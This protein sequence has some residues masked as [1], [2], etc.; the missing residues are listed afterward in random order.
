MPVVTFENEQY[1]G[2]AL[3]G[4]E[5]QIL[6]KQVP[7]MMCARGSFYEELLKEN[8]DKVQGALAVAKQY[9]DA[10]FTGLSAGDGEIGVQKIRAGH[11]LRTTGTTETP[12]NDWA[13]AFTSG[14][15]YW[16]GY[17]T[18]NTTAAN[19]DKEVCLLAL[20]LVFTQTGVPGVEELYWQIGSSI[21]PIEVIRDSWNADNDFGLRAVPIRPK[22]MV[23]KAT[24]LV[25]SRS[26]A[27][28]TNELVVLGVAFGMG[29]FLRQQSYSTVS[30]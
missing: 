17:S 4:A 1:N 15:D 28:V 13:F 26:A 16:V 7:N 21:Y 14:N 24:V 12:N 9:F 18:N 25:Q 30:L 11:L 29:R 27:A 5:L 23:P 2:A 6:Q 20:G 3:S 8:F 22:L 19:I 10:P